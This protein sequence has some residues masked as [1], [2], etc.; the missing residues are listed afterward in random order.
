MVLL[1]SGG[2]D[3]IADKFDISLNAMTWAG[4]IGVLIVPPLAYYVDL[5]DLP[6]PAAARPRGAGARRGDRH[7]QAAAGRRV[8]RGPP[9]AG[10]VDDHGHPIPL[11]YQGA[12]VPKKMNQLGYA[13]APVAG[14]LLR[15]DPVD[16]TLAL[17]QAR[18]D[19]A[20]AEA[21]ARNGDTGDADARES[22]RRELAGRPRDIT[23]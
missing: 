11:A 10:R 16:E 15:P 19:E 6:R 8:H 13:G 21:A 9:A 22:E 1:I 14:S 12:P 20:A 17:E 7:H 18:A 5:P 4:R 23:D 2:N 3:V